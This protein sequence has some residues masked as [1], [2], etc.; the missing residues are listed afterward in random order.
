MNTLKGRISLEAK[1]NN[2]GENV[3]TK[4]LFLKCIYFMYKKNNFQVDYKLAYKSMS[5]RIIKYLEFAGES[6][7]DKMNKLNFSSLLQNSVS[8]C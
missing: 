6:Y 1:A 4:Y 3:L 2:V 8:D 7:L 5:Y